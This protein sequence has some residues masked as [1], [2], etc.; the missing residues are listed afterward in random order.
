[1]ERSGLVH[2]RTV[3][4]CAL[5]ACVALFALGGAPACAAAYHLAPLTRLQLTVVQFASATGDYRRLDAIGA[6]LVVSP[7]GTILVPTLGSIPVSK[8]SPDELATEIATRLQAK[9]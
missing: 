2:S 3:G 5:V 6:E 4:R 1:M 8:L 7:D 9:L